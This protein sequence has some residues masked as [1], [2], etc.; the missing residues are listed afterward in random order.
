MASVIN[1]IKVGSTNYNIASTAYATCATEAA[2]AAKVAYIEGAEATSGFT[3]LTGTTIH[4]K[5]TNTNTAANPTLNVNGTGAKAIMRYGTTAVSTSVY[6]S[7]QAGAIVSLTYDGTNWLLNDHKN[8]NSAAGDITGVTAGNGLTGGATSGAAT[9]NVGQGTGI[10][11]TA[12]AVAANLK[13]TSSLGTIGTTSKLYAVGVDS[14]GNLAVNVPW[15]DTDTNTHNSHKINSGKKSDNSTDIISA[16]ASSGDITLGD[17]G[18]TAGTYKRVTVNAKG[19]VVG[20]DNTDADTHYTK[21]LQIKGNGTEAIKYTQDSDKSLNL[22]P[23]DNVSI[24]AASGEITISA[25]D[26]NTWRPVGTGATDAAA[27]NHTHDVSIAA[28]SGTNELTLAHGTKYALTAGGQSFIFTMPTDNNTNTDRSSLAY[29]ETAAST[30]TKTATMPGFALSSG[31]YI[32]LRTTTTNSATS[33]VTLNVNSTGNKP[34]KIGNS[35]TNPTASNFPAGDYLAKYDGTNWILTRIYLTDTTYSAATTSAAGLMSKDDKSKLDGIATGA[36][37]VTTDTVSGWGYTK[38]TGTVTQVKVG[39]TAYNPSSGVVSL[40]AY[41]SVPTSLKNP[42]SITIKAGSD[43]VSSYD[44]SAAKTFTIAASTTAGAFTISDG[45]TTKT[46]QLAGKFTDTN[47]D[48]NTSHSHS[49]GVGLVGSGSDG[50]SGGT[51]TY[52]AKLR[53]ET[54]LTV[55]SAA[56]TTTSGR[57]YPVVVDK[58]GYLSVNVPWTDTNTDTNTA[59]AADNILDGSNSGTTITYAPY[60]SQQS[61]LSFDTSTTNPTRTDRLNINGYLYGTKLYSGGTEVLTKNTAITGATKCKITYDADGLVT[62]GAN[63]AASDI[64]NLAASKINSGTFDVARIPDLSAKYLPLTGGTLTGDLI[65]AMENKQDL[66]LESDSYESRVVVNGYAGGYAGLYGDGEVYSG[67]DAGTYGPSLNL[68]NS[69]TDHYTKFR[70]DNMVRV[71][72]MGYDEITINYPTQSGTLVVSDSMQPGR[73]ELVG[74]EDSA[75]TYGDII[76]KDA[77]GD[78]QGYFS[79]SEMKISDDLNTFVRIDTESIT[80]S[81][82]AWDEDFYYDFPHKKGTIV[83]YDSEYDDQFI[84]VGSVRGTT[85]S[86]SHLYIDSTQY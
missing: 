6:T 48:T 8:E 52:K 36:T 57:V 43:T 14:N 42:N 81:S 73:L 60:S 27:G 47:T 12:D 82:D 40:P 66:Y 80:K 18:V 33:N 85:L 34:V 15:T 13:S 55:D 35:S 63:L 31:Q 51:Y 79:P 32:F 49:A 2:T 67:A 44:G 22:K 69:D 1:K 29:C 53:S 10:S 25:T 58:S 19:I 11:V 45:T 9:L 41:P 26:T 70:I 4:V 62:A 61:K 74:T 65:I 37:K 16:A 30:A 84:L 7:W 50:T 21:Y 23:G 3:L 86:I 46:V 59:S 39:T 54:A 20:G 5:F 28:S 68:V 75:Q 71:V 78:A 24:S 38:N 56:A 83:V 72:D 17:S 76:L 77:S 64:P